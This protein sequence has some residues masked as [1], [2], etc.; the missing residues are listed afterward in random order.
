MRASGLP[1]I[2]RF[3]RE[4]SS[5][6]LREC[7]QVAKSTVGACAA[8]E[9][10]FDV[11]EGWPWTAAKSAGGCSS[12]GWELGATAQAVRAVAVEAS[13]KERSW[14]H[15]LRGLDDGVGDWPSGV[16]WLGPATELARAVGAEANMKGR[17]RVIN[18][19]L[20]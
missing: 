7:H 6:S 2:A 12:G 18:T 3:T 17:S 13:R 4:S 16:W 5:G 8:W 19:L 15:A 10:G 11:M 1:T 9:V 20:A 14:T